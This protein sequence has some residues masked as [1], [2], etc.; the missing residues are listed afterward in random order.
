MRLIAACA[1]V[2]SSVAL[3]QTSSAPSGTPNTQQ[4]APGMTTRPVANPTPNA[5]AGPNNS[6]GNVNTKG[7][8][9][10]TTGTGSK[11]GSGNE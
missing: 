7:A 1:V 10:G 6:T 5:V 8:G 4:N 2:A 9:P 3:A 11:G